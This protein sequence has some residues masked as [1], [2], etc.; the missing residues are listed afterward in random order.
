MAAI[1]D[2]AA[3]ETPL[4]ATRIAELDLARSAALLGM[5]IYHFSYDLQMFRYLPAGTVTS[6]G[7]AIFARL[8]AGSF[9]AI[10]GVSLVLAHRHGFRRRAFLR[11]LAVIG[12]AAALVS[13][14]TWLAF[15]DAFIFYGILHSIFVA[16]LVGALFLRAPVVLILAVAVAIFA[17][18][19]WVTVPALDDGPLQ[20]LGLSAH[21]GTLDFEPVF[22]WAGLFLFGM[23]AARLAARA[24]WLDRPRPAPGPWARRLGWPGRHSLAVYLLHQPVLLGL[25]AAA[26]WLGS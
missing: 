11:R 18:P 4:A 15:P 22:P 12:A 5:A 3:S 8:V 26:H 7:W 1:P 20:W 23:A 2:P 14:A 21:R 13:L 19:R 17:L 25:V 10:A 9:I 16:S 6:G 24:G